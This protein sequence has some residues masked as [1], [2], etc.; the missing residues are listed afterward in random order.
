MSCGFL[1]KFPS[2]KSPHEILKCLE[3]SY[4]VFLS[5]RKLKILQE[6][7]WIGAGWGV[8][9]WGF[10]APRIDES[11]ILHQ[12]RSVLAVY[13]PPFITVVGPKDKPTLLSLWRRRYPKLSAV[14]RLDFETS[15]V[16]IFAQTPKAY[17]MLVKKFKEHQVKK[18]Y[19]LVMKGMPKQKSWEIKRPSEITRFCWVRSMDEYSIIK[20]HPVTGKRHQIRIHMVQSGYR[21]VGESQYG[22]VDP[23]RTHG[24]RLMLHA[25]SLSVTLP[26]G[27]VTVSCA[28]PADFIC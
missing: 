28:A 13:K 2:R 21:I 10:F 6:H 8:I 5:G 25:Q 11:Q 20:A 17:E 4:S 15:G 27:V 14:H 12:D 24:L 16:V 22:G 1:F 19:V 18:T 23:L 7:S 26:T 3:E 9:P